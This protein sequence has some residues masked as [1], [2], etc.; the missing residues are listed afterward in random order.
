MLPTASRD[1]TGYH[2]GNVWAAQ[3]LRVASCWKGTL[4]GRPFTLTGYGSAEADSAVTLSYAGHNTLLALGLGSPT[5][6][7]FSGSVVC[8]IPSPA[9]GLLYALDVQKARL[10]AEEH[11]AN[12]V[13]QPERVVSTSVDVKPTVSGLPQ[14]Y[15]IGYGVIRTY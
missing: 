1:Q 6:I 4:K 8:F 7:G 3:P 2:Y 5:V 10:L 14:P 9:K 13:C 15:P 12:N 11:Y